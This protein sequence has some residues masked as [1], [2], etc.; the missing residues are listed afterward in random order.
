MKNEEVVRLFDQYAGDIYRLALSY[1][2]SKQDAEDVVQEVYLKLLSKVLTLKPDYEKAYL[3]K[4]TVNRCKNLLKSSAYKDNVALEDA[5]LTRFCELT[6]EERELC[7]VLMR[8]DAK[9]RVPLYLYYYEGYQYKEIARILKIS[10]SAVAMR[11]K[12]G[13]EQLKEKLE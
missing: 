12:R 9:T 11:I 2:G 8:M 7:D 10:E 13:K 1:L 3:M 4:M 6:D 5:A